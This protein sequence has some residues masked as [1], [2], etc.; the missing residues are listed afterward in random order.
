MPL[1]AFRGGNPLERI[2]A[3]SEKC[4]QPAVGLPTQIVNDKGRY[5]QQSAAAEAANS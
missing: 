5:H 1:G 2:V 3:I 4:P